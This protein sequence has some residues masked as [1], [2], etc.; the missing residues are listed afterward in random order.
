IKDY[1]EKF[2]LS[3]ELAGLECRDVKEYA[4]RPGSPAKFDF[5]D[6]EGFIYTVKPDSLW[7]DLFS[8][9]A[10]EDGFVVLFYCDPFGNF[11]ELFTKVIHSRVRELTGMNPLAAATKLFLTKWNS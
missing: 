8:R 3:H 10:K 1:F 2:G 11:F 9:I 6:A 7:I 5:I 4:K